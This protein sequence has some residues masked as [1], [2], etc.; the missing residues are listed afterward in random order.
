[1]QHHP[2][3]SLSVQFER[4]LGA[5]QNSMPAVKAFTSGL[6]VF[7]CS[8][9]FFRN[10]NWRIPLNMSCREEKTFIL[11]NLDIVETCQGILLIL[12]IIE[13]NCVIVG[14]AL[15]P[16]FYHLTKLTILTKLWSL[17]V[18]KLEI[19]F[20]FVPCQGKRCSLEGG[21]ANY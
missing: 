15:H 14:R 16:S 3:F 4:S 9:I 6:V 10:C 21:R 5:I 13:H 8:I 7:Q 18:Q 1:M 12:R 11:L 19:K 20:A 17:L 2:E